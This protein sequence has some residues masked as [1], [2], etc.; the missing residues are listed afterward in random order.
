MANWELAAQRVT[1]LPSGCCFWSCCQEENLLKGMT[2]IH[3]AAISFVSSTGIFELWTVPLA[4]QFY[5]K[6]RAVSSK[7]GFIKAS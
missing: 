2:L 6:G 4:T 3:H 1:S 7:M 5:E